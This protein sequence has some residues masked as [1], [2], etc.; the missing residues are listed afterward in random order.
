LTRR[1]V[2][3]L[4]LAVVLTAGAFAATPQTVTPGTLTVGVALPSEGFQVGVVRGAKVV[5]AQGLEIDLAR[6]LAKELGLG[7]TVFVQS[8]FPGLFSAGAKPWDLA[9][10]EITITDARRATTD[11]SV[12]YMRVDQ[13]VLTAQ[14]VRPTPTTI[15][16]LRTLR[17]CA[18]RGSTGAEVARATVAPAKPV[19]LVANVPTL[20]LDLQTGRC[21][22]VVYDAPALG[23]LKSRAPLRY[24][25]FAGV[26]R[27]RERYAAAI[28]Q[29]S[30]LAGRIN[31]A[32]RALLADG[33][34][35]RLQR[36]WLTAHLEDLPVLR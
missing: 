25:S 7:R 26:I 34:V 10:A 5:Y 21:E 33:T 8:T 16:A 22:A 3:A 29:G 24:G 17:L 14:T 1:L 2:L 30:P 35:E 19:L 28:P 9:L 11:F 31:K 32:L 20:M 27:T 23:T 18:L 12:P 13:G 4:A 15:A 6:A 36:T